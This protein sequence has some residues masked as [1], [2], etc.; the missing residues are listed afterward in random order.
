MWI[1]VDFGVCELSVPK[2]GALWHTHPTP[3]PPKSGD[4][5]SSCSCAWLVDGGWPD[6]DLRDK[7]ASLAKT[8]EGGWSE[9]HWLWEFPVGSATGLKTMKTHSAKDHSYPILMLGDPKPE[10]P[11]DT[12]LLRGSILEPAWVSSHCGC[13]AGSQTGTPQLCS[14]SCQCPAYPESPVPVW[15]R[16]RSGNFYMLVSL[17]YSCFILES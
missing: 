9:L 8:Q 14:C 6:Q 1:R 5:P 2:N 12:W 3:R 4:V 16:M 15:V 10:K 17:R 7:G 13:I 11:L